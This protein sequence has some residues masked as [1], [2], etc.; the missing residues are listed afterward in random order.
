MKLVG[1][2]LATSGS[3]KTAELP[4][5]NDFSLD[6][7]SSDLALQLYFRAKAGA[8]AD[9]FQ[10][11]TVPSAVQ[12]RLGALQLEWGQLP[13][14]AQRALLW[15]SGFAVPPTNEALQV[16]PLTMADLAVLLADFHA[17][18]C[19]EKKCSQPDNSTSS[20]NYYCTGAEMVAAA[21]CVVDDFDD[22]S[23]PNT[24]MWGIGGDPEDEPSY[25]T[26]ATSDENGG[27]G[28][29]VFP[30]YLARNAS[31]AI[32]SKRQ[33]VN[34]SAWVSRWLVE[35]YSVSSAEGIDMV[36]LIAIICGAVVF[37]LVVLLA[38][39]YRR[40]KCASQRDS[41]DQP[42]APTLEDSDTVPDRLVG[43]PNT[44]D[45]AYRDFTSEWNLTLKTLLGSKSLTGKCIPYES[46]KFERAISKGAHGEVWL[47]EYQGQ[48]VAVK[49]LLQTKTLQADEVEEFAKEIELSASLVHHNIVTFIGVAWNSLSNLVM[50][51]EYLPTGDLQRFL[52]DNHA[53]MSWNKDLIRVAVGIGRALEY[54]H[55]R[56]PPLIHR[57]LK[58][59]NILLTAS[60]E[61][62]L[63]DFG[64]SRDCQELSMTAGVGTPYW[65][66]PEI[67][68]GKRY[69]E[70]AD[71]YSFGQ[72]NKPIQILTDVMVGKLRPSFS[73]KCPPRI[74]CIAAECCQLDAF[75]RPTA[76]E[77]V[78]MLQETE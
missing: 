45:P 52:R 55:S 2:Q 34:G 78:K 19:E 27:F 15:D 48:Q 38:V 44:V 51:L 7:I 68:E 11:F 33:Q 8:Q 66:A 77:V 65:T 64:V 3:F 26:C 43:K 59:R 4:S 76:T 5:S 69:T 71:I 53:S 16:W 25:N 70:K 14:I 29:L 58:S 10:S 35:D 47:G 12:T 28:S 36:L 1:R 24:A 39:V 67:L 37:A 18:G 17:V 9:Q 49:R 72:E 21:R 50:V 30:C 42:T 20:S 40:R 6:G 41:G 62:K 74:L 73:D 61:A 23:N 60:L 32:I 31:D 57:D 56:S 54:F 22:S 63:I 46:V 13:G 75:K